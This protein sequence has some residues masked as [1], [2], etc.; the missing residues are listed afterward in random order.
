MPPLTPYRIAV[1]G[2]GPRGLAA[3]ERLAVRLAERPPAREVEILAIDDHAPGSGRIWRPDQ[4]RLLLM[5]TP[6]GEVT[7]FSGPWRGGEPRPGAGPS[8]AQW[9]SGAEPEAGGP[10]AYA[11]RAVYGRYLEFVLDVVRGALPDGVRLRPLRAR[12]DRLRRRPAPEAGWTLTLADGGEPVG[13]GE[14]VDGGE[15]PAGRELVADRV[16]LAT[17]HSVP[18]PGREQRERAAFAARHRL[19][20]VTADSAADMP[21]GRIPAGATVGVLGLGMAFYDVL[22]LLTEGRGGRFEPAGDGLRYLPG[23][24][25]PRLLAGSRSGVPMPARGVNRKRPDYAYRPRLFTLDRVEELRARG[26]IDFERQLMP[27][28]RAELGLVHHEAALR[29]LHGDAAARS[30]TERAVEAALRGPATEPE[31]VVAEE[32][33]RAGLADAAPVDLTAWARPFAGRDFPDR[34]SYQR[35][36]A[37]HLTEDLEHCARGNLDDPLKASVELLRVVRHV[38]RAAVDRSGLTPRSHDGWFLPVFAPVCAQLSS[39]PPVFRVQQVL[40]LLR[41]GVLEVVGPDARFTADA[42][43]GRFTAW[44][45]RVAGAPTPLDGLIDARIPA[46]DVRGDSSPLIRDLVGRGTVTSYVNAWDGELFDTGGLAVTEAPFHP[47]DADGRA[48]DHLYASGIPLEN[49]RWFTQV[50]SGRPG[51]WTDFTR[52]ADAIAEDL[53]AAVAGDRALAAP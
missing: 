48:A 32:A 12:V 2:T 34:A 6:A 39:G 1:I 16:L 40:A 43:T 51:V 28:L 26:R 47:V 22:S 42:A 38:I 25:E 23:G 4:S 19:A 29:G 33:A 37:A 18:R 45:P 13:S 35:E 5:N 36:L 41:A 52:E 27:W 14:P 44:S 21:L 7:M 24:R 30:F 15:P 11:P 53:A 10:A 3:L 8:L 50:G 9:W 31:R 17:G 46:P 49:V 20:H